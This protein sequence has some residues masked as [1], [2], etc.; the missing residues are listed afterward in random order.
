MAEQSTGGRPKPPRDKARPGELSLGDIA[1]VPIFLAT[2]WFVYAL[3]ITLAFAPAVQS[4]APDIGEGRFV[5]AALFAVFLCVSVLIH[6]LGHALTALAYGHG[7]RRITLSLLGGMTEMHAEEQRPGEQAVIAGA[8]PLLSLALGAIGLVVSHQLTE[9]TLPQLLAL[10]VG[11]SNLLVGVFNLLPGLPLDGGQLL[12]ALLWKATGSWHRGT[13]AAA[14]T[15]RALAV[16]VAAS[17]FLMASSRGRSVDTYTLVWAWF[18]A[19]FVWTGASASL[20]GAQVRQRLP[21]LT[22]R[23]LARRAIPVPATMP[24]AEAVRRIAEAGARA[25]VVVDVDDRPVAIVSEAA[26][27]ATPPERRPWITA[28]EVSR[29]LDPDLVLAWDIQ[30]EEL[31]NAMAGNPATEYLVVDGEGKPYGV[32]SSADVERAFAAT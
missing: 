22:A 6:E 5:V 30:G 4:R 23:G 27:S 18:I 1:G 21:G 8:G 12:R 32:L 25:A 2:S 13:V 7:V 26:V 10:A 9:G 24:V 19:F 16:V 17:P 15:G 31:V 29:R 20:K 3:I 28:A 11:F 14:W